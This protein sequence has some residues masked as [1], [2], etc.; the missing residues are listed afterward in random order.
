MNSMWIELA[1]IFRFLRQSAAR[2]LRRSSVRSVKCFMSTS[3]FTVSLWRC[4]SRSAS[5]RASSTVL[6]P[7]TARLAFNLASSLEM[8]LSSFSAERLRSPTASRGH[9]LLFSILVIDTSI[10]SSSA[11]LLSRS[12]R[13]SSLTLFSFALEFCRISASFADFSPSFVSSPSMWS[14]CSSSL[15][16]TSDCAACA[17]I[18]S[19]SSFFATSISSSRFSTSVESSAIFS[20]SSA[21]L[22]SIS[23][24]SGGSSRLAS[25]FSMRARLRSTSL[26]C[27][28]RAL[29]E[30]PIDL[31][32]R[33]NLRTR[34]DAACACSSSWRCSS[35]ACSSSRTPPARLRALSK[36]SIEGPLALHGTK[37][38]EPLVLKTREP[39]RRCADVRREPRA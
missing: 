21:A 2:C 15:S 30:A 34:S 12:L 37:F 14:L 1:V 26:S 4:F 23:E 8:S 11:A 36:L 20:A 7:S 19:S 35:V 39:S 9:T 28:L 13:R 6:L 18:F 31:S 3:A 29:R 17:A 10:S 5:R 32:S 22:A 16:S 33:S 27:L 24:M 25:W 38:L